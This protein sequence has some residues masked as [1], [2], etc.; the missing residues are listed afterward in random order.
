MSAIPLVY[1]RNAQ[2]RSRKVV[3]FKLSDRRYLNG[4]KF[5]LSSTP[6]VDRSIMNTVYNRRVVKKVK[7]SSSKTSINKKVCS[8]GNT[9]SEFASRQTPQTARRVSCRTLEKEMLSN[10]YI[11]SNT[12]LLSNESTDSNN[13]HYNQSVRV[14]QHCLYWISFLFFQ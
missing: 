7:R 2:P 11:F 13:F 14:Y 6:R 4:I 9:T 12:S 10:T 3:V 8:S 1:H 5:I